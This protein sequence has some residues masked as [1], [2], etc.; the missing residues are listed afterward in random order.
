MDLYSAQRPS[1]QILC[2]GIPIEARQGLFNHSPDGFEWGYGGSGPTQ[3]ALAILAHYTKND[4][5]ALKFRYEFK[6][7]FIATAPRE[8]FK[9]TS[10]EIDLWIVETMKND[11]KKSTA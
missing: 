10:E 11:V 5:F 8:G 9:I 1:R 2:N 6:N 4:D 7:K 3:S